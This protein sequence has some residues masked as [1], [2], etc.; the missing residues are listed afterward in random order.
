ME[1]I[2]NRCAGIDVHKQMIM[3]CVLMLGAGGHVEKVVR[4]FRTM[5]RDLLG[6][7][8]WL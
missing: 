6:L 1:R 3:V 7:G 5:T 2:L 4:E 8:D